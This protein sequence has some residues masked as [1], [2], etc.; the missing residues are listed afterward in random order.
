MISMLT[1]S[2]INIILDPIM[3]YALDWGIEGAA[4]ATVFPSNREI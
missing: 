4:I 3:I 1:G 2:I